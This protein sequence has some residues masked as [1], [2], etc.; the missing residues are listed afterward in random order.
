M[1]ARRFR[2][3]PWCL[4][5]AAAACAAEPPVVA[6]QPPSAAA[7]AEWVTQLGSAQFAEREAAS[8]RLAEAG[9]DAVGPL[10]EA[11]AGGDLEVSS[12][13]VEILGGLLASDDADLASAAEK[14]VESLVDG[15]DGASRK[16]ARAAL[17]FHNAGLGQEAL[18]KVESLGAR[19]LPMGPGGFQ[20]VLNSAWRGTSEDLRYLSR[21]R[22]VIHV[23]VHGVKLDEKGLRMLSRMRG[24][25]RLE[26]YGTGLDDAA[27][28]GLRREFPEA[29]VDARRGGKLGV[30]GQPLVGPCLINHVE[31]GSAAADAGIII[32]DVVLKI[33]DVPVANFEELT[34]KVG[35]HAAGETVALTVERTNERGVRE[36]MVRNV[37]LGGWR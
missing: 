18:E 2:M 17:D 3:P 34:A 12:R 19:I 30:G 1:P 14:A 31:D 11:A 29:R 13:A 4:F 27:V 23:G 28:A 37:T 25:Q 26:L 8:R 36:Q 9:I 15:P 7:I 6:A 20:V 24:L 16:L 35:E 21:I 33:D 22:G 32:G 5:V 10:A